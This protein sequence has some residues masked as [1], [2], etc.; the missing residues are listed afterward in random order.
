M[1]DEAH[2]QPVASVEVA[3]LH[4]EC[5]TCGASILIEYEALDQEFGKVDPAHDFGECP[6][7]ETAYDAQAAR[8]SAMV[9]RRKPHQNPEDTTMSDKS[10][11]LYGKFHIERTDGKSAPGEKHHGCDYFVLDL[12]CDPHAAPA[13]RAYADSC[14]AD[15]PQLAADLRAKISQPT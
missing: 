14:E 2:I 10:R 6:E 3:A 13:L 11:G 9:A 1:T 5:G 15:Y 7:C 4:C 12:T 8:F